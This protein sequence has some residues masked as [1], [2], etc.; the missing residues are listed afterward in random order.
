MHGMMVVGE[1]RDMWSESDTACDRCS[2]NPHPIITAVGELTRSPGLYP[3]SSSASHVHSSRW[4]CCGSSCDAS[5]G[6]ILKNCASNPPTSSVNPALT[7]RSL[8]VMQR[9]GLGSRIAHLPCTRNS[10]YVS[11]SSHPA[12]KKIP[13]PMIATFLGC[14]SAVAAAAA[15]VVHV[16]SAA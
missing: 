8:R 3:A 5:R 16:P 2:P 7:L 12:G 1:N 10:Q 11:R 13:R 4:N 15:H 9:S 6:D 14:A